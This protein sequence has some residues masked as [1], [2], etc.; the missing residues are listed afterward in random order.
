MQN[1]AT[2]TYNSTTLAQGNKVSVV[3][4]S[5]AGC[6]SSS[7]EI[8]M[9]VAD[10]IWT[11]NTG[12]DWFNNSNWACGSAPNETNDIIIPTGATRM[13][14][15]NDVGAKFRNIIIENNASLTISGSNNIDVHGNFTNYGS[16]NAN[17]G[18]VTFK[19]TSTISG[20]NS[21]TLNN[22]IID[23]TGTL[24]GSSG[25]INITGDFTNNGSFNNNSG[26]IIFDGNSAQAISGDFAGA[27]SLNNVT[28]NN[29]SGVTLKNGNKT[30]DGVLT[31]TL[32]KLTSADL[33]TLGQNATTNISAASGKVTSYIVGSL[34]KI[35]QGDNNG[36]FF[37][38]IGT[39][40]SY[41]PAGVINVGGG[42]QTW[43][44]SYSIVPQSNNIK[45]GEQIKRVSNKESW[46]ISATGTANIVLSWDENFNGN[47]YVDDLSELRIAHLDTIS[48]WVSIG[49]N[50]STQG[51][52]TTNFGT[53]IS[54]TSISF[55][56]AK[57]SSGPQRFTLASTSLSSNPLPIELLY[58]R[59][60][61]NEENIELLWATVSEI[62][63][64]YFEIQRST[65]AR[66]FK[67]I[68]KVFGAGNSSVKQT[69]NFVDKKPINGISYYRL[70]Q[71]DYNGDINYH[72][73]ISV[74]WHEV[75][76]LKNSD[77]NL[78]PNPYNNGE[79]ILNLQKFETNTS[80]HIS[81][82]NISGKIIY[83]SNL[84]IPEDKNIKIIP[85]LVNKIPQGIYF[86]R[87]QTTQR[88]F[89]KKFIV[90]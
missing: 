60:N 44:M 48:E 11:G 3:A 42:I 56:G 20:S 69:Y 85:M 41:K 79:L 46:I 54:S 35:I 45:I 66:N 2:N 74:E 10:E 6:T 52:P 83:N 34:S 36:E 84:L 30:I 17:S 21:L 78:Y 71:V 32:G 90:N 77:V 73:I 1:G 9:S 15:I 65:D 4:M 38:P 12:N 72:D 87:I 51:V 31:L 61:P 55:T 50:S 57:K 24:T 26:T 37:F 43:K 23:G 62:N 63:N 8:T 89:V 18:S 27:N 49:T 70:K 82:S 59:D 81:I 13:P 80:I 64:D 68:G 7:N 28:I 14:V 88:V 25:N 29:L 58:F 33:L 76:L 67:T 5:A 19:G 86:I 40:T 16:F 22:V 75:N 39:S 53:I 47:S